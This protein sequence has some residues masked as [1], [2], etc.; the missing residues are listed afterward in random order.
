MNRGVIVTDL[1][2]VT[3]DPVTVTGVPML[4]TM[5]GFLMFEIVT[6]LLMLFMVIG[7]LILDKVTGFLMLMVTGLIFIKWDVSMGS[8]SPSLSST[9]CSNMFSAPSIALKK[10]T[11]SHQV[12]LW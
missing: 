10:V 8:R 7:F 9:S 4:V 6:G 11:L 1:V 3:G 12:E 2:T 5:T